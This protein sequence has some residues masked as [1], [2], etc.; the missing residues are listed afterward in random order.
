M[1]LATADDILI[2]DPEAE[3]YPLVERLGGQVV[4]I[5]PVSRQYVNPL[6]LNLNYSDDENPL[7]LKVDFILS[8]CDVIIG[9]KDG[10]QPIEKTV[11]DRCVRA[12]YRD[13]LVEPT[14]EK[15]PILEDLYKELLQQ[16]EPEAKRIAAALELY[17][18]GSL[19]VFN[20]RTNVDI[21]KRIVCYDIKELGKQLKQLGMLVIQD[22]VWNR[23]TV[24]RAAG[25]STRY[26]VDEFHLLLKGELAAWSVEIWKRFRKWGGIPTGATQNSKDLLASPEISNILENSDFILMLNQARGDRD[27]LARQLN[28]SPHQLSY[29]TQSGAGEGLLFYGNVILPFVDHF[30]QD[31]SLYRLLTTKLSEMQEQ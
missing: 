18:T 29:V 3:Y 25:K 14:P 24:N 9:S 16:P 10:L 23:V 1:F 17:V 11:I 21:N 31:N 20:H 27:I 19:N 8:F 12:I 30:P 26:Y 7:S 15:M 6:D 22:Q 4:K 2:C 13:F 5:S 28:I